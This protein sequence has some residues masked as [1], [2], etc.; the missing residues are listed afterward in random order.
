MKGKKYVMSV[1]T[2]AMIFLCL[3][4]ITNATQIKQKSKTKDYIVVDQGK[5]GDYNSIQQAINNAKSGSKI[6]VKKGEYNEVVYLDKSLSLLGED[7]KSTL[8]NPISEKNKY[9]IC[10]GAQYI[11]IENFT[12]MNRAPGLYSTAIKV[13][14][15][16]TEI[17]NCIVQ[18]T[19]VGI[20]IWTSGNIVNNCDFRECED[21]GIAFL[22]W[23]NSNCRNNK[24]LNCTF[25]ENCDGIELQFSTYNIIKDCEF[26]RNT[27]TGIDAIASSNDN[28]K[29][30]NCIIKDNKVNGIY[31]SS[32]S[33]NEIIDCELSDNIDGDIV[34]NKQSKNN[35]IIY[36][37][38]DETKN[39]NKNSI[40]DIIQR[41]LQKFE[42]ISN[43]NLKDILSS[44][45]F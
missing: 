17:N 35:Q 37:D 19:P 1:F 36:T 15:P 14:K 43:S 5:N 38:H 10:L 11:K 39:E 26:Y 40:N 24:V 44:I 9:A 20:A 18:N 23:K 22:G 13:T 33:D 25:T 16:N 42:K 6:Y 7:K 21:E 2:I 29:I 3:S 45:N 28:N 32:S 31:F 4:L 8:I 12:I 30:I 27:H 41:I 34:T